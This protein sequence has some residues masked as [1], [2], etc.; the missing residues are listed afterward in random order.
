MSN[1]YTIS[2][3]KTIV[4]ANASTLPSKRA[5]TNA[6]YRLADYTATEIVRIWGYVVE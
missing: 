6:S 3:K 1:E 2:G 5:K 4:D